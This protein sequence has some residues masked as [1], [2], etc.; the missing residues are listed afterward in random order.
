MSQI[1]TNFQREES[2]ESDITLHAWGHVVQMKGG[3]EVTEV[4]I[5]R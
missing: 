4:S 2:T 3:A 5:E 1:E